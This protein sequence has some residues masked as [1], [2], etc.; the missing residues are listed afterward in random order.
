MINK[1][2]FKK[3][4]LI[5]ILALLIVCI[6][7]FA[8][9]NKKSND[10]TALI[11]SDG[12]IVYEI[13]LSENTEKKVYHFDDKKCEIIVDKDKIYFSQSDCPDKTCIKSGHLSK[14]GEFAACLPNNVII[15]LKN[16]NNPKVDAI[17]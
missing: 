6:I 10:T 5:L 11:Y 15:V 14:S 13:N 3:Q 12:V 7:L 8:F 2:L 9:I 17:I 1:K 4:D 16:G